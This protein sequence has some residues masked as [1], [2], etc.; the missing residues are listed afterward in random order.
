MCAPFFDKPRQL[1]EAPARAD[2][3]SDTRRCG[4]NACDAAGRFKIAGDPH[5]P[6]PRVSTPTGRAQQEECH[7][8]RKSQWSFLFLRDS[9]V[10]SSAA[11]RHLVVCLADMRFVVRLKPATCSPKARGGTGGVL[12]VATDSGDNTTRVCVCDLSNHHKT[13][14]GAHRSHI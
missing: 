5:R 7:R 4:R 9:I 1:K 6:G 11:F 10:S 3:P 12:P 2:H 13:P 8:P 14:P